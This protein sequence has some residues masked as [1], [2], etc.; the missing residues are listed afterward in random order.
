MRNTFAHQD[1]KTNA[2]KKFGA[3]ELRRTSSCCAIHLSRLRQPT[4]H[5]RRECMP[6]QRL[7][8]YIAPAPATPTLLVEYIFSAPAVSYA[9]PAPAAY[10]APAPVAMCI[11]KAPAVSYAAQSRQRTPLRRQRWSVNK[12]GILD[13]LQQPQINYAALVQ[14]FSAGGEAHGSRSRSPRRASS[15][16]EV[17]Q[18]RSQLWSAPPSKVPSC[19]KGLG[20]GVTASLQLSSCRATHNTRSSCARCASAN[21]R[22]FHADA[23]RVMA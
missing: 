9:A 23:H 22:L 14:L 10:A 15:C 2:W 18:L 1:L 19:V 20:L 13:V 11:S 17:H 5:Q 8:K 4:L 3:I 16:G 21:G 7:M 6:L 12:D